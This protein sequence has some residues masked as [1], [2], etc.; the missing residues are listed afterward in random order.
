[1]RSSSTWTRTRRSQQWKWPTAAPS[2]TRASTASTRRAECALGSSTPPLPWCVLP[3]VPSRR[4][5]WRELLGT[6]VLEACAASLWEAGGGAA[7]GHAHPPRPTAVPAALG[8][9][10]QA[11]QA[12]QGPGVQPWVAPAE[13][14]R[15]Q[16]TEDSWLR[17]TAASSM[18]A[19]VPHPPPLQGT[20]SGL[21]QCSQVPAWPTSCSPRSR[22][23]GFS[24][25]PRMTLT[26]GASKS[27]RWVAAP[28]PRGQALGQSGRLRGGSGAASASS[29]PPPAPTPTRRPVALAWSLLLASLGNWTRLL[30]GP[31]VAGAGPG[32][33]PPLLSQRRLQGG[34]SVL[35]PGGL[36]APLTAASR[37]QLSLLGGALPMFEL[38]E[39]QPSHL[40]CPDVL[41]L[42]LGEPRPR[43]RGHLS[44]GAVVPPVVPRGACDAAVCLSLAP[45][46]QR[47]LLLTFKICMNPRCDHWV[48]S[49]CHVGP[50]TLPSVP[51]S[52]WV[53]QPDPPFF[54]PR[55]AAWPHTRGSEWLPTGP[56]AP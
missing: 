20:T 51:C 21:P 18:G 45:Q 42:S 46:A 50:G 39:Q 52:P 44:G 2:R 10:L 55:A 11:W 41:N 56:G 54:A 30:A 38:V 33:R 15:A 40:A 48:T 6:G 28:R 19:T 14:R 16:G 25:R 53:Q 4:L 9:E 35:R 29:L 13:R 3:S 7:R 49:V 37:R 32:W 36:C 17:V 1:M 26:T 27:R 24:A 23:R 47:Q 31:R 8:A 5:L 34:A 43:P 12:G 22:S